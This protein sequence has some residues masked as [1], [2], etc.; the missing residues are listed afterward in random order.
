MKPTTKKQKKGSKKVVKAKKSPKQA[1]KK[2][3]K[4]KPYGSQTIEEKA[5][6]GIVYHIELRGKLYKGFEKAH[7]SDL[8]KKELGEG[9]KEPSANKIFNQAIADFLEKR[10][11]YTSED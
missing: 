2:T 9:K 6:R 4:K 3:A 11:F 1:A 5:K 10:G 8:L 7:T